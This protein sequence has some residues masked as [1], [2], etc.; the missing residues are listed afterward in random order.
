M[1]GIDQF[2]AARWSTRCGKFEHFARVRQNSIEIPIVPF[3][4]IDKGIGVN[5]DTLALYAP[6]E[7]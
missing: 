2:H 6:Q 7:W 1:Q 3:Q 4:E 5:V